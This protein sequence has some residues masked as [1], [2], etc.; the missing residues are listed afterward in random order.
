M[1]AGDSWVLHLFFIYLND[2]YLVLPFRM[3]FVK[4]AQSCSLSLHHTHLY[5]GAS[6]P[7]LHTFHSILTQVWLYSTLYRAT[8]YFLF[9]FSVIR[10]MLS[11]SNG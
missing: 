5:Y 9:V 11:K 1:L 8:S 6:P 10:Y 2:A 7:F 3:R 4:L